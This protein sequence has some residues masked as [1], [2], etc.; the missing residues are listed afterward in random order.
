MK[1]VIEQTWN[2]V[3]FLHW[4]VDPS[5]LKELVP[6]DLDLFEGEAVIS[7]VPFRMEQIRFPYCPRVPFFS[8]LWE[9]NLRTYVT[10]NG[11]AGIYFFTLD[12]D[13]KLGQWI[14]LKF[15]RLPYRVTT[16]DASLDQSEFQF[17]SVIG[18]EH[19]HLLANPSSELKVKSKLDVWA[20]ERYSVFLDHQGKTYQG[21]VSH[22]PWP[23]Q[24]ISVLSLENQF[25]ERF[26][27][28]LMGE[29]LESS[30]SPSLRVRFAPF[31]CLG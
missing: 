17:R 30:Y 25:S 7:I 26:G 18:S 24:K 19:F 9:L 14:A 31:Q 8:S 11:Q 6:F 3:V 20:T 13:S 28:S 2:H 1:W 15:F 22:A 12:T 10:V 23:L 16:I 29:P 5:L 21:R 4:K 27:V